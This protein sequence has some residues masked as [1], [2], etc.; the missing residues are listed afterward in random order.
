MK[1]MK[2]EVEI[3]LLTNSPGG[4]QATRQA[5]PPVGLLSFSLLLVMVHLQGC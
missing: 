1:S 5:Q 2:D 4:S 3:K